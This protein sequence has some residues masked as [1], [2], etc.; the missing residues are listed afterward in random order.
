MGISEITAGGGRPR[1]VGQPLGGCKTF[2]GLLGEAVPSQRLARASPTTLICLA[3]RECGCRYRIIG[4][5]EGRRKR[6]VSECK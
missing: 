6:S 3:H 2:Q 1:G 4:E 5:K